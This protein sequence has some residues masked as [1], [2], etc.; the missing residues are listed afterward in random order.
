M[1]G[2]KFRV[3][4]TSFPSYIL[5]FG[6]KILFISKNMARKLNNVYEILQALRCFFR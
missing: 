2:V 1:F 6:Q 3:Q 5:N 4:I